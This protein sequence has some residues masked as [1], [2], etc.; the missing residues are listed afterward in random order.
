MQFTYLMRRAANVN[1][2]IISYFKKRYNYMKLKNKNFTIISNNCWGG[3]VYQ[4]YGLEYT[5]PTIGLYLYE[6]DYI[7][8][9]SDLEKYLSYE[10]IFIQ[11]KQSKF[12]DKLCL[13]F[14]PEKLDFPIAQIL[15]VEIMFL[16]YKKSDEAKKKWDRRKKRINY[17]NILFK[18]SDR[19]DCNEDIIRT[20]CA[21]PYKNKI[22]FTKKEYPDLECTV[23]VDELNNLPNGI[24]EKDSTLKY[25][26][27]TD[28]LNNMDIEP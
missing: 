23:C 17:S 11:P 5:S 28:L 10:L 16:H 20:F 9:V 25:I 6:S 3:D 18:L 19:T 8:F 27:I 12:Y 15:D 26:D 24:T 7:K 2:K 1:V 13:E 4:M 22:C 21:L 14:G